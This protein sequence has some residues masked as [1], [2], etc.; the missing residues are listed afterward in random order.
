MAMRG[1]PGTGSVQIGPAARDLEALMAN[2]EIG[3]YALRRLADA[4][5]ELAELA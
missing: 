3:Q 5:D 4:I 1:M 2:L